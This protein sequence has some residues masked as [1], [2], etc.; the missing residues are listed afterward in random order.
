[1]TRELETLIDD[2]LAAYCDPDKARRA[3]A[4][5]RIWS[6]DGHLADPPFEARG[7]SAIG[8]LADAV[9]A[10]YPGHTFRRTTRLDTHHGFVRYG[11]ALVSAAGAPA[12]EGVDFM[13]IGPD[14]RI[15]RA[16][17]FFGAPVPLA[18]E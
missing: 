17:G 6:Q 12:A 2:H 15:A 13:Q 16:V 7:P 11:W 5:A 3:E 8:E 10:N 18:G 1:M 4:L 14:G 9:V